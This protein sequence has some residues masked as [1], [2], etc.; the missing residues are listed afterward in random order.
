MYRF[1]CLKVNR[2]FPI[3][4]KQIELSYTGEQISGD[5]GLLLLR[6][7][8]TQRELIYFINSCFADTGDLRYVIHSMFV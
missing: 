2:F 1:F 4:D 5:G 3:R 6:E 8:V 7:V